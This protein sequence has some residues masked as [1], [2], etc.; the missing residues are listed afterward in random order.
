MMKNHDLKKVV[1]VGGG[2]GGLSAAKALSKVRGLSLTLVDQRNHHLFQ[3]L[4]YQVATAGLSPAEIAVP[5][6][7]EFSPKDNVET[8]MAKVLAVDVLNKKVETDSGSLAYDFLILACGANQSYFGHDEWE[9][10]APG[11]KTVEQA[12]EIRRRVLLAFEQAEKEKDADFKKALMTFAVVGGG[13]TG[14]ELAG[15][16][17]EISRY[18]L[19]KD[20]KNID[21]ESARVILIEAGD[22]ILKSFSPKLSQSAGRFLESRGVQVWRNTRVTNV[23]ANGVTMGD[24]TLAAKTVIWAAGVEPSSLNKD[25]NTKLDKQ[26]RVI[27]GKDLSLPHHPEI[28]VIGD[29]AA[30]EEKDGEYLPGLAP[31]AIQQGRFLKQLFLNELSGKARPK[32]KYRDKG[33]MATIGRKMAVMEFSG[34]KIAGVWAWLSWLVVHIYYL[35]GFRNRVFVFLQWAWLYLTYHRGARLIVN[36]EWRLK[37]KP[38]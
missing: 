18:T 8:L 19:S 7:G 17:G 23:S 5:I 16:L 33:Q 12:T 22:R 13:P 26:G 21:P 4:L 36:K 2:F 9:E 31:V 27:V 28:F 1:I 34:I 35:I 30:F 14:V 25:L 29:Q 38:D 10:F 32:F 24:E 3:P 37:K 20:F 6:R 11:L 15:A